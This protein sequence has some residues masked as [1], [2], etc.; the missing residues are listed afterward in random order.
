MTARMITCNDL[1]KNEAD[2]KKISDIF[3]ALQ[4]SATPAA[5][6]LAWFPSLAR[7]LAKEAT[8]ELFTALQTYI[9]NRRDAE[10]TS[11]AIDVLIAEGETTQSIVEVGP[12]P[13]VT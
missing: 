8:T 12:A 11:D 10:P 2:L 5:L 13:K 6:L 1:A 9:E 3:M 7:R 4:T